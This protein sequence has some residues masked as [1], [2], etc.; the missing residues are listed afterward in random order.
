MPLVLATLVVSLFGTVQ[1]LAVKRSPAILCESIP[2]PDLLGVSAISV[3][4]TERYDIFLNIDTYF[5]DG[6]L[7]IIGN[8]VLQ[9]ATINV[10]E[11]NVTYTHAGVNDNVTVHMYL[12]LDNWN[13]RFQANGGGGFYAGYAGPGLAPAAFHGYATANSDTPDV[14]DY[15]GTPRGLKGGLL[16]PLTPATDFGFANKEVINQ[17]Q[18]A[19]FA[20]RGLHEMAVIGKAVTASFYGTPPKYSY[21]TGCSTGGRQGYTIVQRYPNDFDGVLANA[22]GIYWNPLMISFL[23]PMV[24]MMEANIFL[25]RCQLQAFDRGFISECDGLDGVIDGIVGDLNNC[26]FNPSSMVGQNIS[27][28]GRDWTVSEAEA[29]IV[30]KIHGGVTTKSGRRLW[31][32]YNYGTTLTV[33]NTTVLDNGTIVPG[34]NIIPAT[35]IP[36]FLQGDPSF[37]VLS[38]T[39]DD[40]VEL[41]A[42]TSIQWGGSIGSDITDI[43][44][45]RD[46][47]GK[48]LTWHGLADENVPSNATV[49]YRTLVEGIMGGN[50]LVNEWYRTFFAPGAG[51]CGSNSGYGPVPTDSFAA[52]VDWVEKGI[53]PETLPAAYTDANGREWKKN[54]CPF[55]KVARYNGKGDPTLAGSYSCAD[56]YISAE[57]E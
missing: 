25:S 32:G 31:F 57:S 51:H 28:D 12:P 23:W 27:C 29:D 9:N 55:P 18:W 24:P 56:S 42:Q 48:F 45:F 37:D 3:S 13:G 21:Y 43:T 53:A 1:S 33:V 41:F 7:P 15:Y 38:L 16:T 22:P 8:P 6:V 30:R 5:P 35:W 44:A 49:Y 26:T 19:D 46:A 39:L 4:A 52:L 40:V 36:Y 47:G 2:V 14:A 34:V 20:S 10:C 17:G 50:D 54:L 11:V